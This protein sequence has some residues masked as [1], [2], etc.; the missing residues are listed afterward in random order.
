VREARAAADVLAAAPNAPNGSSS[1]ALAVVLSTIAYF[2]ATSRPAYEQE[3]YVKGGELRGYQLEGV[4][5]LLRQHEMGVNVL[6]ADEMV[7]NDPVLYG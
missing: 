1:A 5:W 3:D 2:T 4:S 6:L 7:G